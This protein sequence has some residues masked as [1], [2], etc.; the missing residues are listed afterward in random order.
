MRRREFVTLL[1]GTA[2]WP[3][4]AGALQA[5]QLR[6]LGFLSPSTPGQEDSAFLEALQQLGWRDG[7]NIR[8]D[9]RHEREDLQTAAVR[10]LA[11][12]PDVTLSVGADALKALQEHTQSVP[13]VFTIITDPIGSGFVRSLARPGGNVTGFMTFE[14]S[15]VGKWIAVLKEL[16]PQVNHATVIDSPDKPEWPGYA[17]V[18]ATVAQSLGMTIVPEF[19]RNTA[20]IE[21]SIDNSAREPNGGLIVMPD[22]I[23]N[24]N[25]ELI[26]GLVA[27]HGLPAIYPYRMYVAGGGLVSYGIDRIDIFRRAASYVDRILRGEKPGDLPVQAPTKFELAVNLKTAKALGL[28]IPESFLVRADEVIE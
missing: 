24:E 20:D 2:V 3:L 14:F 11:L 9:S 23:T 19:V 17:R 18:I 7:E 27:Q 15:I 4:A 21:H 5:D 10:L 12:Q 13:I 1:G 28:T 8:I 22:R 6:R 25:R 26:A 16:A